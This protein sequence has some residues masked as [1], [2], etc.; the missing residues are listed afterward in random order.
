MD[1]HAGQSPQQHSQ[2]KSKQQHELKV[3][4]LME[5]QM[6][7]AHKMARGK[8]VLAPLALPKC[9]HRLLPSSLEEDNTLS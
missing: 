2:Q 5:Q 6:S 4:A 9:L 1:R 8:T 7:Q 3:D